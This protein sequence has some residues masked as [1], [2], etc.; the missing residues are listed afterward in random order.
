MTCEVRKP[1]IVASADKLPFP[2]ESF[3]LYLSDPPYTTADSAKYGCKPYPLA[4]AMAEAHRILRPGGHFGILHT[5]YPSY[6]RKN[7][8]L[9]GLIAVVTG[10]KRATRMFSIFEKLGA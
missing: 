4:K 5:Y 2:A 9:G 1:Q 6:R 3:D 10:F 8:K 7:W